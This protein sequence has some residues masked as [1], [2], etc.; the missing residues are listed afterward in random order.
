MKL[1]NLLTVICVLSVITLIVY[2]YPQ[3]QTSFVPDY[4]YQD[5]DYPTEAAG[6]STMS[7]GNPSETY[8]PPPAYNQHEM[9]KSNE[10]YSNVD[11]KFIVKLVFSGIFTL[12]ALYVI[13]SPQDKYD[14]E[15][16]KWAFSI[17]ALVTG[18]WLGTAV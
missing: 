17:I 12:A 13:L 3:P 2:S 14:A 8:T 4:E 7:S 9:F 6:D 1:L 18:I 16:K 10:S 15:T 11:A 5:E